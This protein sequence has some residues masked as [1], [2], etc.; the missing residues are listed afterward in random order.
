MTWFSMLVLA[1]IFGAVFFVAAFLSASGKHQHANMETSQVIPGGYAHLPHST[2]H[3]PECMRANQDD[4]QYCGACGADLHDD[5]RRYHVLLTATGPSKIYAIK[6]IRRSL[7]LGL[8]EAK[9]IADRP[10]QVVGLHLNEE[11]ARRLCEGFTR[12]G[13]TVET[14][15]AA[16]T[17]SSMHAA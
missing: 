16:P 6:M 9:D 14:R 7:K 1:A 15:L 12:A 10:P 11:Q 17:D 5:S 13:S 4:A 8:K 2:C 3:R